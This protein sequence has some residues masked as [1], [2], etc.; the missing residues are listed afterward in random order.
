MN[1]R[2]AGGLIVELN[3]GCGIY[4]PELLIELYQLENAVLPPP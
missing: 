2:I 3:F 1:G 4:S